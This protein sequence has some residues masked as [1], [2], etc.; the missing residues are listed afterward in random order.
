[1]FISFNQLMLFTYT[2]FLELRYLPLN[3]IAALLQFWGKTSM[4]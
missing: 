2:N 4:I 3:T 1:M